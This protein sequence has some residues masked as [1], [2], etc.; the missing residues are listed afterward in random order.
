MTRTQTN[1]TPFALLVNHTGLTVRQAFGWAS[2]RDE[3]VELSVTY[4][5]ADGVWLAFPVGGPWTDAED[6]LPSCSGSDPVAVLA[7]LLTR[8]ALHLEER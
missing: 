4:D 5:P 2:E 1:W 8:P 7:E 6:T 3:Y